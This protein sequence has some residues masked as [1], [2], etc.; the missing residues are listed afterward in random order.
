M[1]RGDESDGGRP[2]AGLS[3]V[4]AAAFSVVWDHLVVEHEPRP[5]DAIFCFGSR[6]WRV[7]QRAAALFAMG[8]APV[9]LVSGAPADPDGPCEADVF[10]ADLVAA[11]VPA[12]RIVLERHATNTGENVELGVAALRHHLEPSRITAVSWPLATRRCRATFAKVH[13]AIEVAS[14]PALPRPGARWAPTLRRIRFA[15]GE[16]DRLERYAGLGHIVAQPRPAEV[17][18]ATEV[19]RAEVQRSDG[20]FSR[21]PEAASTHHASGVQLEAPRAQVDPE[22]ASLPLVER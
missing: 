20:G 19:L 13:P 7:P 3:G 1:H 14:S 10:A 11:G 18:R 8:V 16:L 17:Q 4:A 21:G 12:E 2:H 9:V 5:S 22:D 15:L 6:H